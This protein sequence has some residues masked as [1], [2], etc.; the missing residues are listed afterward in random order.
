MKLDTTVAVDLND[1]EEFVTDEKFTRYLLDNTTDFG[2]AAFILQSV[3][4]AVERAREEIA[5]GSL[6]IE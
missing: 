3:L 6:D 5:D 2:T 4:T 1:V